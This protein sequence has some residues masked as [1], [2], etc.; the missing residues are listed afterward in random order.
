[1]LNL[2]EGTTAAWRLEAGVGGM[3]RRA[4]WPQW[5]RKTF[6]ITPLAPGFV[7]AKRSPAA[8]VILKGTLDNFIKC[9]KIHIG[10]LYAFKP[11]QKFGNQNEMFWP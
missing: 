4:L 2:Q 5:G 11:P 1:M 9:G 6:A 3:G 8:L 10:S 7:I